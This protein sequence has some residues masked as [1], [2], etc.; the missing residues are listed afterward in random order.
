MD[1]LDDLEPPP[2]VDPFAGAAAQAE[3]RLRHLVHWMDAPLRFC[4]FIWGLVRCARA[5]AWLHGR[6]RRV[7]GASQAPVRT[8]G[9]ARRVARSKILLAAH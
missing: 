6:R 2:A 4:E 1:G 3:Q 7:C 9:R 5:R 8:R